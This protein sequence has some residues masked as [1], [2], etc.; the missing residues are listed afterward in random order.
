MF[1]WPQAN[2]KIS[3]TISKRTFANATRLGQLLLSDNHVLE[4]VSAATKLHI[5]VQISGTLHGNGWDGVPLESF[6]AVQDHI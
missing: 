2:N 3:G 5:P 4:S 6:L 1:V